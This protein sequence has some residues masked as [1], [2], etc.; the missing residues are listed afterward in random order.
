[1][2]PTARTQTI[3]PAMTTQDI[4]VVYAEQGMAEAEGK[5]QNIFLNNSFVAL[6]CSRIPSSVLLVG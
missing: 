4:R 6:S 5:R 1:M 3:L 2:Y